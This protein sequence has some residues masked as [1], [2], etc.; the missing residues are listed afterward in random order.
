MVNLKDV[1]WLGTAVLVATPFIALYTIFFVPLCW[2]TALWTLSYYFFTGLGITAGYH[3]LWS[4]RSYE[5]TRPYQVVAALAGAGAVQGSIKW[6]SRHHRA[7]HRWTDTDA[8]PYS[9]HKGF[10]HSH[11]LWIFMKED[12]KKRGKVDMTDL[13]QDPLVMFQHKFFVP[14]MLFMGFVLP[15]I[16]AGFGW[17]DWRGGY[18]W[19]AITRLVFVQHATFCVNSLAHWL[20][21]TSFDDRNSPR[22]HYITALMTLGEGYHNFHHEFPSDFRNA[23][24]F[25]QY[26]PTKWLIWMASK[27]GLTYNLNMFPD[28]EIQKGR[29]QM[30]AKKIEALKAKLDWGV[31]L[32]SL[33]TVDFE[34]FQ[35]LVKVEGRQL[36]IIEGLVYDVEKFIDHHPG[37]RL[38][39]KSSIGRD[40]T[41]AFNGGVY[42][43][44]T[45]ARNLLSGFRYAVLQGAVPETAKDKDE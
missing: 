12:H 27:I 15:T 8:D 1:D 39:I 21:E 10:W 30:Q 16:V 2:Q 23:V 6:W 20:G 17:G 18:Y 9:A 34:E 14:I 22:D 31:P 26:D 42:N 13:N 24:L 38:F 33:P 3:R 19:A 36:I 11:I 41:S 40:A 32:E 37:G 43:H 28:N 25:W 35:N 29:L 5:A 4:H 44:H 7:H 45:A